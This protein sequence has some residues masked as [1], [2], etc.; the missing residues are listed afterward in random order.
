MTYA[1]YILSEEVES[2]QKVVKKSSMSVVACLMACMMFAMPVFAIELLS[3]FI[4]A[5]EIVKISAEWNDG[6][7]S[8]IRKRLQKQILLI[9]LITLLC[10]VGAYYVGIPFLSLIYATDLSLYKMSFLTLLVSGGF[11]AVA[12]YVIVVLTIM[13]R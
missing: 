1:L 3:S 8:V 5:P 10:L 7:R 6:K 2:M 12:S 13:R 11:L 9:A 4:Y